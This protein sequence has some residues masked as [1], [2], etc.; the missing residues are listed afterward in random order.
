LA[1]I[2]RWGEVGEGVAD[3]ARRVAQECDAEA[4]AAELARLLSHSLDPANPRGAEQAARVI[5]EVGRLPA[6]KKAGFF[7]SVAGVPGRTAPGAAE[8]VRQRLIEAFPEASERRQ[9]LGEALVSLSGGEPKALSRS[10]LESK[11]ARAIASLG[12]AAPTAAQAK[13]ELRDQVERQRGY[14]PFAAASGQAGIAVAASTVAQPAGPTALPGRAEPLGTLL[15][16]IA[17]VSAETGGLATPAT[18]ATISAAPVARRPDVG[19]GGEWQVAHRAPP[20]D[21]LDQEALAEALGQPL[22]PPVPPPA[23]AAP[24]VPPGVL[25]TT[26]L[27]TPVSASTVSLKAALAKVGLEWTPHVEPVRWEASARSLMAPTVARLAEHA[28]G[29]IRGV[30]QARET[31]WASADPNARVRYGVELA[32]EHFDRILGMAGAL[33]QAARA[34]APAAKPGFFSRLLEAKKGLAEIREQALGAGRELQEVLRF[35]KGRGIQTALGEVRQMQR[36]ALLGAGELRLGGGRAAMLADAAEPALAAPALVAEAAPGLDARAAAL[37]AQADLAPASLAQAGAPAG[38]EEPAAPTDTDRAAAPEAQ[39]PPAPVSALVP[40][41][42]EEDLAAIG[43]ALDP[44]KPP[45]QTFWSDTMVNL[46]SSEGRKQGGLSEEQGA[47]DAEAARQALEGRGQ[48]RLELTAADLAAVLKKAGVDL[49]RVDPNQVVAAV[50]YLNGTSSLPAQQEELRKVIDSFHVLGRIGLPKVPREHLLG[51]LDRF[52]H[53]PRKATEKLSDAELQAKFQEIAATFNAGGELQTKIGKYNLKLSVNEQGQITKSECKKPGF[54][55]KIGGFFK[56][57][58]PVVL[59][60][61]SFIPVTAPFAR[62]IQA[63][64]SLYKSIKS[65][66][67]LGIATAAANLVGA[68][69]TAI[70]GKAANV[71]GSVASRIATIANSTARALQGV[72]AMR[73]GNVL[74]G[75]ANI[76]GAVASGIGGLAGAT[77]EKLKHFGKT[78]GDVSDGMLKAATGLNAAQAY[79]R[80]GRAVDE[81]K[82]ALAAAQASGD[83]RQIDAARRQLD[84]AERAKKG[85]LYGGLGSAV[86]VAADLAA[87]KKTP[88]PGQALNQQPAFGLDAA[89]RAASRGLSL[90]GNVA[91]ED[92]ESAGVNALGMAAAIQAGL[93]PPKPTEPHTEAEWRAAEAR[94]RMEQILG[95]A[96]RIRTLN[97]ASNLADAALAYRQ[98]DK[99]ETAANA[100]VAEAERALAAAQ[101]TGEPEAIRQAEA[102]LSRARRAAEGALMGS[103]AAGDALMTTPQAITSRRRA[104]HEFEGAVDAYDE[105][106]ATKARAARLANRSGP[107]T[108]TG[109][110]AAGEWSRL[111]AAKERYERDLSEAHGDPD[112]IKAAVARFRDEQAEV[113]TR[114][115]AIESKAQGPVYGDGFGA[116]PSEARIIPASAQQGTTPPRDIRAEARK[117]VEIDERILA[118]ADGE[119]RRTAHRDR[120]GFSYADPRLVRAADDMRKALSEL[121]AM[122]DDPNATDQDILAASLRLNVALPTR[123]SWASTRSWRSSVPG[124]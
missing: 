17:D 1:G 115:A 48:A 70:A 42:T 100:G 117:H 66:S 64:I 62:A 88:A 50:R 34:L 55:S 2:D 6:D 120:E 53:L 63:G 54:F 20:S 7:A 111:N 13:P 91:T 83:S 5:A 51:Q 86:M 97:D 122:G 85:A 39:G 41:F 49:A 95:A 72:S 105:F 25:R 78:L 44:S 61:A 43:S 112:R 116:P 101:Q 114:L 113:G 28:S 82:R 90:T 35:A 46:V 98:S 75:L 93:R 109:E 12:L 124:H 68:G 84:E 77:A 106:L 65:K 108:E 36:A 71:A 58:A 52:P 103:I 38:A 94:K 81:A 69:V 73:Q 76:G 29:F 19:L 27:G 123:C 21:R 99:A 33:G 87:S 3:E 79:Q 107:F 110:A 102:N 56:K 23:S 8:L 118:D 40:D 16:D 15:G 67:L 92:W 74:G 11:A 32:D 26:A 9:R 59:T 60:V 22:P 31:L 89:L 57:I 80:A 37:G 18:S 121:K 45:A 4:R 30:A 119:I 10:M 96:P 24:P 104:A 14:G 47:K